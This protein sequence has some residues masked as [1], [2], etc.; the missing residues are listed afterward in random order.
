MKNAVLE[1]GPKNMFNMRKNGNKWSERL[2][3][4]AT[5]M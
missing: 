3:D 1:S 4:V 5:E 2:G